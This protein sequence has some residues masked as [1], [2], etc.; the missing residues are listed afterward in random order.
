MPRV[1][2]LPATMLFLMLATRGAG[3]T[4][5]LPLT[6][7]DLVRLSDT[8]AHVRVLSVRTEGTSG[9]SFRVT[10]VEVLE[11]F[12]GARPGERFDIWQ[13]GGPGSLVMGD[14]FLNAGQQG[15]VFLRHVNGR[16]YLTALAQSWWRIDGDGDDTMARRDLSGLTIVHH[17]QR[18]PLP[19]DELR[20][21]EL[22]DRVAR[23]CQGRR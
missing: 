7:A 10:E 4:T 1:S 2:L 12:A 3:A 20:W 8:V 15:L 21:S 18:T 19:P 6:L 11:D 14:P 17:G 13:R 9:T 16:T 23:E 22:R 5:A